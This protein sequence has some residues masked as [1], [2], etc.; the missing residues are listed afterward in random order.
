[1]D[2]GLYR[3]TTGNKVFGALKGAVD[4]GIYI[5]HNEKRF[6]GFKVIKAAAATGKKG[7][8]TNEKAKKQT[9]FDPKVLREHIFGVHIQKYMDDLKKKDK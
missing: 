2:V 8:Q 7:K 3:T 6:P 9:E 1:M 4:G 5:P